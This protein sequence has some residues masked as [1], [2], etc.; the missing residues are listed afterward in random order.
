MHQHADSTVKK[1]AGVWSLGRMVQRRCQ[2]MVVQYSH[3]STPVSHVAVP[4]K[5]TQLEE[6]IRLSAHEI[7]AGRRA[8][9][10]KCTKCV[11]CLAANEV[12]T[13]ASERCALHPTA[14]WVASIFDQEDAEPQYEEDEHQNDAWQVVFD[15]GDEV[16]KSALHPRLGAMSVHQEH[17]IF[18]HRDVIGC[19][20]CGRYSM[21]VDRKL[22]RGCLGNPPKLGIEVVGLVPLSAP[23]AFRF[24]ARSSCVSDCQGGA[25]RGKRK[26]RS[27][28]P[29]RLGCQH[30]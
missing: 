2:H 27:S 19:V 4:R 14:V 11:A 29:C 5:R 23:S 1:I 10:V 3:K 21:W 28:S 26:M 25:H 12:H 18:H 24:A 13:V 30:F 8:G 6:C 17:R 16:Q 15:T 9:S 7:V 20:K 22:R